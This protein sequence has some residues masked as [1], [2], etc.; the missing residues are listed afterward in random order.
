MDLVIV[1]AGRAGGSLALASTAAGHGVVGI[2]SR[3]PQ[4][5]A[6]ALDWDQPLPPSDLVFVAV[7]DSTIASVAN[8]LA[9]HW[10]PTRPAAHLSGFASTS[11]LAPIAATGAA[12]GS[13]HPL[14]TLPDPE[15]GAA[16]LSGA[17]AAV[18]ADDDDLARL[19]AD[20][21][22]SLGMHP[23]SLADADKGVYHAAA[24][25]GSNY[26]VEALA[27]AADLLATAGVDLEVMG[28]LTRRVVENVF[29]IGPTAA[30]TG[31]I[32]RG[33]VETVSGQMAAADAVSSGLGRQ[34]RLMAQ[35]TAERVGIDL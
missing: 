17:W 6:P 12:V 1:G 24:A 26:V 30:L 8:R 15:R 2:L 18:T 21:A 5:Y 27:V 4:S 28:P 9:A 35:A 33:D 7:S 34:F 20:F 22:D 31:P 23:F 3:R 29:A 25:A 19:L 32:A 16:A 13:F 10:S 11:D 14:Q